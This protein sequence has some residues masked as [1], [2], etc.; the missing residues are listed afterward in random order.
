[1]CNFVEV[2]VYMLFQ[3]VSCV[4]V[5]LCRLFTAGYDFFAPPEAVVYHLWSRAHRRTQAVDALQLL[6][7]SSPIATTPTTISPS[8]S[9]VHSNQQAAV[10]DQHKRQ[11]Q[12][13]VRSMLTPAA[14]SLAKPRDDYG[15]GCVRTLEEFAARARIDLVSEFV[16][17]KAGTKV[18]ATRS[19]T[20]GQTTC[21]ANTYFGDGLVIN[22][23]LYTVKMASSVIEDMFR[24]SSSGASGYPQTPLKLG[25]TLGT[26]QSATR[27]R[28]DSNVASMLASLKVPNSPKPVDQQNQQHEA[29]NPTET[30]VDADDGSTFRP[31]SG[32]DDG[33]CA[34]AT[35][36]P[37]SSQS[38]PA[39]L[40]PAT[41]ST[42][43]V[44]IQGQN[45]RPLP[46]LDANKKLEALELVRQFMNR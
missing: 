41:A 31:S 24:A 19:P 13:R 27:R 29:A 7:A 23:G 45:Q 2:C 15:L 10:V 20:M 3:Y 30:A 18:N 14:A 32:R 38:V 11:S 26:P 17:T 35:V 12:H 40:A 42:S 34:P 22:N 36:V 43:A 33:I 44:D 46:S 8:S 37:T 5:C 16:Y 4:C 28:S 21:V 1:V 25:S 39:R 6:S 9:S